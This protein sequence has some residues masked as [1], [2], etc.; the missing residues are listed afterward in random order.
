M[1]GGES[2]PWVCS[3]PWCRAGLDAVPWGLAPSW[4]AGAS[5]PICASLGSGDV[6]PREGATRHVV[7]GVEQDVGQALF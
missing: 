5:E 1:N 7:S 3:G 4:A 2:V 6:W